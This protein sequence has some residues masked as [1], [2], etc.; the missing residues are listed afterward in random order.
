MKRKKRIFVNI[1]ELLKASREEKGM[2]Q[3]ELS[4][5]IGFDNG[6]FIS[7][8]ERGQCS[9]PPKYFKK[10][11]K[12]LGIEPMLFIKSVLMDYEN[13]LKMFI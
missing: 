9:L 1:A 11:S 8:I 4:K 6:Q 2:S 7:N 12:L 13:N 10:T 5:K 3:Y